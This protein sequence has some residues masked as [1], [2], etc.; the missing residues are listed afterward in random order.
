MHE[1][2]FRLI[3]KRISATWISF[4]VI[5][6]KKRKEEIR[7]TPAFQ[8]DLIVAFSPFDVENAID[9][10]GT[11][12]LPKETWFLFKKQTI[13]WLFSEGKEPVWTARTNGR[14]IVYKKSI[15]P[16]WTSLF[17]NR[18]FWDVR[19]LKCSGLDEYSFFFLNAHACAKRKRTHCRKI[20]PEWIYLLSQQLR[21]RKRH[22]DQ[23]HSAVG[24]SEFIRWLL[25]GTSR[26]KVTHIYQPKRLVGFLERGKEKRMGGLPLSCVRHSFSE[27]VML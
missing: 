26:C 22:D 13:G 11:G 14:Y 4:S 2:R 18:N 21:Q 15:F 8:A 24:T 20:P 19:F 12:A 6:R 27:C 3:L 9:I 16:V 25:N 1:K 10:K 23:N 17:D 7:V 5:A